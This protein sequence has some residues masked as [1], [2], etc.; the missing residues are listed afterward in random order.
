MKL[1]VYSSK[2]A[3]A[4]AAAQHAKGLLTTTIREKGHVRLI[5]ATGASQLEFLEQLTSLPGIDWDKVELFHLDEYIGISE[6]HPASFRR[7][8]RARLIEKAGI[9]KY[10]LIDGTRPTDEVMAEVGAAIQSAPIDIAFVGIGENGHIAFNDPP[11]DFIN[12]DAYVVVTLD[13]PCRQ[14][15]FG[16]GWFPTLD[17]VPHRAISM[18]VRQIMAST[19]IIAVVPDAR[20][21]QAVKDC[22]EGDVSP[23]HPASILREHANATLYLEPE[24]A[25]K[26]STEAIETFSR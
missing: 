7:Y 11:A 24:S 25:A 21:A 16:E 19:N 9:H 4:E 3:L 6:K 5:A 12:T 13:E 15:Q 1:A 23:L 10:H 26:L 20:K 22:L 18:T 14:Q 2:A 8:L 17:D